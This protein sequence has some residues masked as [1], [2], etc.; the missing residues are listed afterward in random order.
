MKLQNLEKYNED[1]KVLNEQLQI[2]NQCKD[3]ANNN[4]HKVIDRKEE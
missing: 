2:E 4:L 3:D 1:L